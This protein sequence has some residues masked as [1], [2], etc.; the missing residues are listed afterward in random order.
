MAAVDIFSLV[1]KIVLKNNGV[2]EALKDTAKEAEKTGKSL[3]QIADES[4]K[5]M[6]QVKSDVMKSA[7]EYKRSGMSMSEAMQKAYSDIGYSAEKVEKKTAS[8][9]DQF[10]NIATKAGTFAKKAAITGAALTATL[11]TPIVAAGKKM[12]SAASDYNEALSKTEVAFGSASQ[13]VVEFSETS[14]K[15]F[16]IGKGTALDMASLFGDMATSMGLPQE[17]AA[18]MS[19]SLTG[20]AGDLAS[21]QNI[22]QDQA[23]T[24]LN[25]IFTGET[26]SLKQVGVVMTQTNLDAF[27]LA[28]GFGKTT[29]QMTQAEQVQLRY[30]YVMEH[31][32]NAQGDYARTLPGTANSIRDFQGSIQ[33]LGITFGQVLLP[34]ITP[35]IQ[36]ST[37]FIKSLNDI[38]DPVKKLI[39]VI[40]GLVAAI[41]PLLVGAGAV[42]GA[43]KE[44]SEVFGPVIIHFLGAEAT[45]GSLG[46]ALLTLL[47]PIAAVI[48]AVAGISALLVAVWQNSEQFRTSVAVAFV[49]ISDT[50]GIAFLRIKEAMQ[51]VIVAF[52][53]AW[54]QLQPVFQQIGDFL[55]KYIIPILTD[56]LTLVING[57]ANLMVALAPFIAVVGNVLSF[58]I[59]IIGMIIALL[60]GD[61]SGAFEFAKKA[62]DSL[63]DAVNN[64]FDGIWGII[65]LVVQNVIGTIGNLVG[66]I[67]AIPDKFWEIVGG[68]QEAWNTICGIMSGD[69]PFPHI[70]LPHIRISGEWSLNPPNAP[71]FGIDWYANGAILDKPTIFGAL[72]N[73]FLG[74]GEAGKEAI[75]PID[76]LKTY[77][78]DA[79]SEAQ[80]GS[81]VTSAL[82]EIVGLL[83]QILDKDVDIGDGSALIKALSDA[84][85]PYQDKTIYRNQRNKNLGFGR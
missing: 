39:I 11:T 60:N 43:V 79:V 27:A 26:E 23:M 71:D 53:N 50:A 70:P 56:V 1:G 44:I 32:K 78:R 37:A 64:V 38:P 81:D 77:V 28:H 10:D 6:N 84:L 30:A 62:I 29:D 61:F 52:S 35:M 57:I 4:G 65:S 24:A 76:A 34:V 48:A 55:A 73:K 5:T 82:L 3:R 19:I 13:K 33:E 25:G 14:L 31:T 21:F 45:A 54:V 67:Q 40:A 74:A 15:S 20:L 16:G 66:G 72:G 7:A 12:I 8:L 46:S 9:A 47:G 49:K 69:I 17:A 58:I 18:D 22:S 63:F 80:G 85:L 51:P 83:N 59:N 36:H 41:G 42:A 75:T 68:V 2:N